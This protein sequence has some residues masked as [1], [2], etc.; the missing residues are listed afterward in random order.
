MKAE[1][2]LAV[3][4]AAAAF[5]V[6]LLCT[7]VVRIDLCKGSEMYPSLRDGDL[8]I[9]ARLCTFRTGDIAAYK[10][11]QSGRLRLS[12][13]AAM[14]G[15]SVDINEYGEFLVNNMIAAAFEFYGTEPAEGSEQKYPLALAEDEFFL[16]D[17]NRPAGNDSRSFGPVKGKELISKVVFVIRR[18][19]F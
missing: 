15:C 11:P 13:I 1:S 19:G 16:L 3:K 10:D 17:D 2:R 12:R 5:V 6:S 7:F 4:I 8:V 9:S 14:P 18:R